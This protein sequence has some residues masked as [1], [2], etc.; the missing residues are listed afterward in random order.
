MK[1]LLIVAALA[2]VQAVAAVVAIQ[3]RMTAKKRIPD[4]L[5]MLLGRFR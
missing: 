4:G 1:R 2:V 3:V 5:I